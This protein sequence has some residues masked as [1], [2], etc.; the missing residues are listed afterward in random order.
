MDNSSHHPV[1]IFIMAW[2]SFSRPRTPAAKC[3]HLIRLQ[4][5][6]SRSELVRATGLSQPTVTRAIAALVDAGYVTERNDLTQSQGRGRPTIPLELAETT[7]THAGVSVGTDST[8]IAL[9]DLK[10]RTLRSVDVDLPVSRM[11]EDD[12][13]QHI[14]AGLNKLTTSVGR[15]LATVGVTTSGTVRGSGD[16]YAPNLGWDGVNIGDQMREQFSVPVQVTSI[17]SAIVGSEM[18]STADL[19]T[20]SVMA[21]FADDSLACAIS[22][23]EGVNP[24]EVEQGELTTQG[25]LDAIDVPTIRTLRQAVEDAGEATRSA[26][27]SRARGLG[28]LVA[29]LCSDHCPN[30]VVVA[31]SAF[32]DDPLASAPFAR[33]VREHISGPIDLRLIPSHKDVVRDIA[34]AVALDYVLREPLAVAGK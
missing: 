4:E 33:T 28:T 3:L 25:L 19:D 22:S 17:S 8:Y 2:A 31:G 1:N 20:P 34:R 9:F 11:S 26:L 12:F 16:V 7:E 23:P 32:I 6:T 27:D 21:L 13:I 29:G 18:Q 15:P 10:G 24:I 14:M 5:L 30:T